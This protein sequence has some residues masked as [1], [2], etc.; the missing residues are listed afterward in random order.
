MRGDFDGRIARA[1]QLTRQFPAS[2][3][4]LDFYTELAAFQ[5]TI[6][7]AAPDTPG[8]LARH[9]PRLIALIESSG[10]EPLKRYAQEQLHAPVQHRQLVDSVWPFC[11]PDSP[12]ARFYARTL[13]QPCA[14]RMAARADLTASPSSSPSPSSGTCPFCDARPVAGILRG[15]G[16]GAKRSLLCSL[17]ATEWPF[18]RVFCANCGEEQKDQLP[19][20]TTGQIAH[21]QVEACDTCRMYLKSVNLTKDGFAIPE[22]DEIAAAALD[23]WA[24]DNDYSKLEPN[25][26]GM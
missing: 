24:D 11:L 23:V 1:R 16:D 20:Y 13:L 8:A 15:E 4:L 21:V 3:A 12:E 7:A 19:I 22:V 6:W 10:P 26:L 14:E 5:Q 18:R 25:L 9:V 17:C 2:A